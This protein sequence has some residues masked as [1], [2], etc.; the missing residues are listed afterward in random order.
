MKKITLILGFLLITIGLLFWGLNT[1]YRYLIESKEQFTSGKVAKA[2][3]ILEKGQKK[4]PD[5]YKINFALAKAYLSTGETE[6]ANELVTKKEILLALKKYKDF[7]DFLI[8][9]SEANQHLGN[10]NLAQF[11]STQYLNY[12]DPDEIS[13]RL[14]KN[15]LR[16]GQILQ[17]KSVKLWEK[18]YNIANA[19]K[20]SELK[21]SLKA[22]LLPK[23][24][25]AVETLRQDME[26]NAALEILKRAEVTGIN[27]RINYLEALTYNDLGKIALAQKQFE[28]TIELEPNDEDYK[29]SYANILKRAALNTKDQTK[30]TEYF[31]KIKLLLGNNEDNPRIVSILNKI[32]N[33][34]A[35]YK[36]TNDELT[37][38]MVGDY[39]YPSLAFKIKPISDT[40][41]RK[42]KIVFL[43]DNKNNVDVYEAPITDGEVNQLIEVTCRNPVSDVSFVNAKLFLNDEFVKEYTNK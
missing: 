42:F 6:Q 40:L 43:D 12:Q 37:I 27:P 29:I 5:N 28:E 13:K 36:I 35:K 33:L 25:Q 38:T 21:E 14:V 9:L 4:Y 26:Y 32:I 2:I 8:D 15:Y 10:E 19:L 11:F 17:D 20:E 41:L 39:L 30:K 7:Q 34:N 18:A 16:I 22:L 31:E 24:F 1:P 23:Y 3:E